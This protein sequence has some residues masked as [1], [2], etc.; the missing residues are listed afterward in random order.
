MNDKIFTKE[1]LIPLILT[2]LVFAADQITKA[3]IVK[4]IPPFTIGWSFF[5]DFFRIIHVSNDGIA[6]S[7]GESLPLNVR[8]ILFKFA[9]SIVILVVFVIYFRNE[10]FS[11]LQRWCITGILGGG[12]GNL[13]DRVFR[14]EGVVDFLDFKFYGLFGLERWPTFNVAD[15][16]VVICGILLIVSFVVTEIKNSKESDKSEEN[17]NVGEK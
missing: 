12:L 13:W 10:E 4:F 16:A 5:D 8:S 6:F 7:M 9:P 17:S 11:K 14:A 2:V 15:M 1:K 3:L